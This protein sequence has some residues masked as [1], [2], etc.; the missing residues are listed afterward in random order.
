MTQDQQP[1]RQRCHDPQIVRN[2]HVS[3]VVPLLQITQQIHHLRL[4]QHVEGA[5]RLIK[6]DERR[7]ENQCA[8]NGDALALTAREL[9]R[10]AKSGLRVEPDVG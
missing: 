9:V 4:D 3:E 5:G 1:A 6:H 10:I 7:L 8:R 2:E